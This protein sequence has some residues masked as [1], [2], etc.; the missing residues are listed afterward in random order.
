MTSFKRLITFT[1]LCVSLC[2]LT[3]LLLTPTEAGANGRPDCEGKLGAYTP[4]LGGDRAFSLGTVETSCDLS[5]VTVKLISG[6]RILAQHHTVSHGAFIRV[7]T[8]S[9]RW[10]GCKTVRTHV[11]WRG[12]FVGWGYSYDK[13]RSSKSRKICF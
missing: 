8:S 10:K 11:R 2:C 4:S 3:A 13:S 6:G 12:G 9:I 5:D 1:L 7:T